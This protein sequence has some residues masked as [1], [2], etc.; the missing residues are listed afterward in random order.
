[1]SVGQG[2]DLLARPTLLAYVH[3]DE[4]DSP[5]PIKYRELL[6][7]IAH[8]CCQILRTIKCGGG[9]RRP[10]AVSGNARL[11]EQSLEV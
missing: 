7:Y 9:L 6:R 11:A 2:E 8:G 1:M 3:P 5:E 10:V 4:L